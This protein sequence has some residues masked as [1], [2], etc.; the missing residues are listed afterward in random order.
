[1]IVAHL[2]AIFT[3]FRGIGER[4]FK[5]THRIGNGKINQNDIPEF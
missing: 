5:K 1:M 2:Y 4:G 3:A